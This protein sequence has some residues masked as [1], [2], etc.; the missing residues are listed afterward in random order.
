MCL[1][2]PGIDVAAE[3][4]EPR[5]FPGGEFC[6]H[7]MLG[8]NGNPK[9][10]EGKTVYIIMLPGPFKS[11][12]ELVQR[13]FLT[14]RAAKENYARK[15]VL[16]ATDMPHARQDRGPEEDEK[17]EGELN[18][19][20]AH[21]CQ[22]KAGGIDQIIT[23]HPHTSRIYSLAAVEYDL[24]PAEL[25]GV[26]YPRDPRSVKIPYHVDPNEKAVQ[27][28]GKKVVNVIGMHTILADYLLYHSSLAE[29]DSLADGGARLS[30]KAMDRGNREFVDAL[31]DALFL[32]NIGRI[33]CNKVR[34][35][36]GDPN[37]VEVDIAEV[38]NLDSLDGKTEIYADDGL[39]TGGTM[40]KAAR[41]SEEGNVCNLSG[42]GY[43]VP[44]DRIVYFTHA[45]LGGAGHNG[46]EER[47]SKELPTREF[48]TTNTRPYVGDTRALHHKFRR[49]VSILKL[50]ALWGDAM[51][52]NELGHNLEERYSGFASQEEQHEFVAELFRIER[53]TRH[54]MVEP[55]E[56]GRKT[57]KFTLREFAA[58]KELAHTHTDNPSF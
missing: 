55:A 19:L 8:V 22:F 58:R 17:A 53:D 56:T 27:E 51:R 43:G 20:R 13:A 35:A 15:V 46:I 45:W 54:F 36:K 33:Y 44:K 34:K 21:M 42:R 52:A 2:K 48:V 25:R 47:L 29:K 18:T 10:L 50:A 24:V 3:Y 14:A 5:K 38:R 40:I 9:T 49:R 6:P 28:S 23:A 39:D 37:K 1:G 26:D 7:F 4:T 16:V 31:G 30:L 11:P 57:L 41:W 12:E 32:P